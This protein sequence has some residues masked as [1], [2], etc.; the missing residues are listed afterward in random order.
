ML[1]RYYTKLDALADK[2]EVFKIDVIGDAYMCATNLVKD[3]PTDHVKK[4]A[5][6]AADAIS[7]ASETLI[8]ENDPELGYIQIRCGFRKLL[9]FYVSGI[10]LNLPIFQTLVLLSL[11][12]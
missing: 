10:E 2:Y 1:D 11:K 3:Q 8:D 7:S 12:L 4:M 6:F 5:A 9:P